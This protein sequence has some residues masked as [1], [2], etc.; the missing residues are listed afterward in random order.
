MQIVVEQ[1]FWEL[2]PSAQIGLVMA[3]G[4]DNQRGQEQ[5]AALLE[6]A[7]GEAVAKP[8]GAA[9]AEH[10]AVAPWRVA[11]SQFG[12]K[13]SA[14][15]SSIES[16]I[17]SAQSGRLRSI[18][19]LVDLYNAVSLR[20]LLPCGGEDLDTIAGTIRL[21]R[22]RGDESFRT[23][24]ATADDPPKAG[25]VIY[26]DDLGA[27]CRCWNWREADRTKLTS[28]TRRAILVIEALPAHDPALLPAALAEL[29]TLVREVLGGQTETAILVRERPAYTH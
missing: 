1:P 28:E 19:P 14:F 18:N 25:E 3:T 20:F 13:P 9:I 17:R 12:A 4:I 23:I 2:F 11:Y 6:Q 8:G 5:A 15:R 16:L 29:A 7:I 27:I 26:A 10:P 22:A 24:G 21:T